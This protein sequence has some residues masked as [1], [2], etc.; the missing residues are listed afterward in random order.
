MRIGADDLP[1][2]RAMLAKIADENLASLPDDLPASDP[3]RAVA[4][5]V[6]TSFNTG[7][8]AAVVDP[9]RRADAQAASAAVVFELIADPSRQ[10]SWDG[11]DNL[12]HAPDGQRVIMSLQQGGNANLFVMDLRSKNTTRR[13]RISWSIRP[14]QSEPGGCRHSDWGRLGALHVSCDQPSSS[15]SFLAFERVYEPFSIR[16]FLNGRLMATCSALTVSSRQ[17]G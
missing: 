6:S 9:V 15:T 11:N 10:P 17:S 16:P 14:D 13:R 1:E 2:F 12:G 7:F 8:V 3:Q 5:A 4:V